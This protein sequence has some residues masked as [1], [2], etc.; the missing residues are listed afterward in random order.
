VALAEAADALAVAARGV[1]FPVLL[2]LVTLGSALSGDWRD[3]TFR[4]LVN[5]GVC[6][7]S[8]C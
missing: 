3:V 7:S 2:F 8:S 5:E 4:G 6:S 1:A